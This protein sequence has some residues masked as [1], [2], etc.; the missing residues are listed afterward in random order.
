MQYIKSKEEPPVS[1]GSI[2]SCH[3]LGKIFFTV[4]REPCPWIPT[5]NGR[6]MFATAKVS[7][8]TLEL[9]RYY[10]L[11]YADLLD[12]AG[13]V[14]TIPDRQALA[15][16][17]RWIKKQGDFEGLLVKRIKHG[18][19]A[20]RNREIIRSNSFE[21]ITT[22]QIKVIGPE[23][24]S[25]GGGPFY[26][27]VSSKDILNYFRVLEDAVGASSMRK[28]PKDG[29]R[30]LKEGLPEKEDKV[31]TCYHLAV[32]IGRKNE[33]NGGTMWAMFYKE[34]G[35][36]RCPGMSV[37]ELAPPRT[38][39]GQWTW[40]EINK[41][42]VKHNSRHNVIFEPAFQPT[43]HNRSWHGVEGYNELRALIRY[44]FLRGAAYLGQGM[45]WPELKMPLRQAFIEDLHKA[46]TRFQGGDSDAPDGGQI[47]DE[48]VKEYGYNIYV[49]SRNRPETPHNRLNEE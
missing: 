41:N 39:S 27:G 26:S 5:V 18:S 12:N 22:G 4:G 45:E 7:G 32:M 19:E 2:R 17:V 42:G 1:R 46:C 38:G 35:D 13:I 24:G 3:D 28:L 20:T 10:I 14:T 31:K 33:P 37:R 6:K 21:D 16:A 34:R 36:T 9:L 15:E 47:I 11:L 48:K 25:T 8:L 23:T 30:F 40:L 29:I 43:V 44:H 49:L